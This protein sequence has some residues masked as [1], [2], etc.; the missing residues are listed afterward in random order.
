MKLHFEEELRDFDEKFA[1]CSARIKGPLTAVP[2]KVTCKSCKKT[3][4]YREIMDE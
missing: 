1:A 4:S 3:T 2:H